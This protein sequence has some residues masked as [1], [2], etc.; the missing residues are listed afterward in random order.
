MLFWRCESQKMIETKLDWINNKT[1]YEVNWRQFTDKGDI[2]SLKE[3]IPRLKEMGVGILWFMPIH[4]IGKEN[5][6][7]ELGSYYSVK[8]YFTVNPELGTLEEFKNLVD[9]IHEMDMYV[10]LDWV[11]NHTACDN[12]MVIQH[13]EWYTKNKFG[14]F[15]PPKGTD[16]SDVYDL[17][18]SQEDL[19]NYMINAMEFWV[20]EIDIDGFRCDVAGMVPTEFW[21]L[22]VAK[23]QS[24][25]S[26]FMLAEWEEPELLDK[27][28]HADY[29]WSLYHIL[30]DKRHPSQLPCYQN[31]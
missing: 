20:K 27:A 9:Y 1:I 22:A 4:P 19:R 3:H 17:D 18:Y 5:R 14:D 21:E 23:L 15:Q 16:W 24:I 8:D 26:V 10:I 31:L 13:P 29:N 30:K 6:K 28:F 12:K 11:A 25:K 2:H 7:G